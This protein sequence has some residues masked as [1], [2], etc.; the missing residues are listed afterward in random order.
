VLV[1]LPQVHAGFLLA[2]RYEMVRALGAGGM[3]IVY[4]ARDRWLNETVALK[5]LRPDVAATSEM[6]QRFISAI[7][8]ARTVSHRNVCRI[9]EYGEERPGWTAMYR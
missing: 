1:P 4:E 2:S 7:K 9:H 8:M 6:R 5:V 3:G